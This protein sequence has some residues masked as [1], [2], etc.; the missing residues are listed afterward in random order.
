MIQTGLLKEKMREKGVTQKKLADLLE[1]KQPTVSQKLNNDRPMDLE[2]AEIVAKAL[3]ISDEEF[4][5]YF[6]ASMIA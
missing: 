3:G 5:K 1:L 4:R 2:E 6:F